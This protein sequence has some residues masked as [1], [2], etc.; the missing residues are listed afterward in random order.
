MAST[1]SLLMPSY[2]IVPFPPFISALASFRQPSFPCTLWLGAEQLFLS[3]AEPAR[4]PSRASAG[5]ETVLFLFI[6]V[7]L[8]S[9]LGLPLSTTVEVAVFGT[10]ASKDLFELSVTGWMSARQSSLADSAVDTGLKRGSFDML[11]WT[12]LVSVCDPCAAPAGMDLAAKT[13]PVEFLL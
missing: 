4:L 11:S 12:S 9:L 1:N 13:W 2:C 7:C 5:F 3:V 8:S 10:V 6:F